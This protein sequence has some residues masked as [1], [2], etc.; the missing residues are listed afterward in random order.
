MWDQVKQ[1]E[2]RL[3]RRSWISYIIEG[4]EDQ[5]RANSDPSPRSSADPFSSSVQRWPHKESGLCKDT[6]ECPASCTLDFLPTL[7]RPPAFISLPCRVDGWPRS[8]ILS[9]TTLSSL[10]H[11]PSNTPAWPPSHLF[12]PCFYPSCQQQLERNHTALQIDGHHSLQVALNHSW[13][14]SPPQ[15]P[16]VCHYFPLSTEGFPNFLLCPETFGTYCITPPV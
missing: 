3:W 6:T 9:S 7:Q 4:A 10:S 15:W 2:C 11:C 13:P 8:Q 5:T 14:L 1:R 12:C 16:S